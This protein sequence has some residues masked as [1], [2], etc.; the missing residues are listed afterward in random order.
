MIPILF[1]YNETD[2]TTHGL[3]DLID[4]KE[5]K[6]VFEDSGQ[7]ELAF[8]YP[9]NGE[10]FNELTI[11]RIILAKVNHYDDHYQIFRIY[12]YEKNLDNTITVDCQHISYDLVRCP[13]K[14]FEMQN[15]YKV[16][17]DTV[18]NHNSKM[19]FIRT[20]ESPNYEYSQFYGSSFNAGTTYYEINSTANVQQILNEMGNH[21]PSM[22]TSN[23]SRFTF[24]S[25]IEGPA[26]NQERRFKMEE[27]K[28][29]R[30][31]LLD[32]DDSIIG[33]FG[34]DIIFDN[35]NVSINRVGGA[36]RGVV[37][38]YGVDLKDL[39]QEENIS[40]MVTGV[41]PYYRYSNDNNKDVTVY[42]DIQYAITSEAQS[43]S[44][45]TYEKFDNIQML[46]VTEYFPNQENNTAPS[47]AEINNVAKLWIKEEELGEPDID[48]TISYAQLGQDVRIY[49]Q[50]V[51]R[52]VKLGIDVAAKVCKYSYDVLNEKV[53]EVTVGKARKNLLFSLEDASRLKKGL[54]PPSRIQKKSITS[55]KYSP[56][57]VGS[58]A[59]GTTAVHDWHIGDEE[60]TT[61]TIATS[62]V[63]EDKIKNSAVTVN[64][65]K[66]GAVI[67]DKI[68][69]DQV[70]TSKVLNKAI[71]LAKLSEELQVF[72]ADT[73]AANNIVSN[74]LS[75]NWTEINKLK[76]WEGLSVGE[77]GGS[78]AITL[79][80]IQ[81]IV[82][83]YHHFEESNGV[84]SITTETADQ[85]SFRIAD[86]QAYI[87]GVSAARNGV[88]IASIALNGS[89][90]YSST[91]K[92]YSVPIIATA[93]NGNQGTETIMVGATAA[94]NAGYANGYANGQSSGSGGITKIYITS[95]SGNS[96]GVRAYHSSGSYDFHWLDPGDYW[97]GYN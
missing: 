83:H 46:D 16:T 85:G 77:A 80:N 76:V 56:G 71:E 6:A 86:T 3:G 13:I 27:P 68:L 36:N 54:L 35:F 4:C 8:K 25:D 95:I 57:S 30:G 59:I 62:A 65:I 51:V 48:L 50:I 24:T 11:N 90:S 81:L 19:Y 53:I 42:G 28:S 20:G 22:R 63:E 55:E 44:S 58:G 69:D 7:Y 15:T 75:S 1:E 38:E 94:Y 2:F 26:V 97:D 89:A 31:V 9:K 67:T 17:S 29:A 45:E 5:C 93:D 18:P 84:I 21:A 73:I 74:F 37:I 61:R 92:R 34:G 10:L 79:N 96:V 14:N 33:S 23:L 47:V 64:K 12:G 41:L 88:E 52:F 78:A 39:S 49:D 66:D 32:G 91:Y 87:D 40:E 72:Y 70:T 60:I 82:P 43:A